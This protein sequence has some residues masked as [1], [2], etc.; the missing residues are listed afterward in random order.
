MLLDSF[1]PIRSHSSSSSLPWN[2]IKIKFGELELDSNRTLESYDITDFS[3]LSLSIDKQPETFVIKYCPTISVFIEFGN[4][5]RT[6][7]LVSGEKIEKIKLFSIKEFCIEEIRLVSSGMQ[8]NE[9]KFVGQYNLKDGSTIEVVPLEKGGS[10]KS[11]TC[12][13]NP[14][15]RCKACN[16]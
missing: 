12:G 10:S 5:I 13:E 2:I 11:C 7:Q 16:K 9:N 6:L 8:L 4:K 3:T 1:A 14:K 15:Q